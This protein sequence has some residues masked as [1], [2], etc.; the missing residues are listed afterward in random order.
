MD[1]WILADCQSLLRFMD[2]EMRGKHPLE[3]ESS[4]PSHFNV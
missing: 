4:L 2:E 3:A 1:R